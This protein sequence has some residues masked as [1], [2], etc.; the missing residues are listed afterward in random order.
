MPPP[1]SRTG[2]P[3]WVSAPVIGLRLPPP[4]P[5]C[6]WKPRSNALKAEFPCRKLWI[7]DSK[8]SDA[9]EDV[10][11]SAVKSM[12]LW[13]AWTRAVAG[14]DVLERAWEPVLCLTVGADGEGTGATEEWDRLW[15]DAAGA[16]AD[17]AADAE[18]DA[19]AGADA[20][21][22]EV[23]G[24]TLLVLEESGVAGLLRREVKPA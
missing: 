22:D 4:C 21:V 23:M 1:S 11:G 8:L 20:D 12:S 17:A 13:R 18:A 6:T 3:S 24:G 7:L 5:E 9:K 14:L 2:V 19:A 15:D 16:E 10:S